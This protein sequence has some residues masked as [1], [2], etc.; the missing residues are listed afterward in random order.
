[1]QKNT[2]RIILGVVLVAI[3]VGGFIV[4]RPWFQDRTVSVTVNETIERP[5]LNIAFTFPSGEDAYSY[6]EPVFDASSTPGGPE[7][8]FIMMKSDAYTDY[9]NAAEGSD[10]PPVMSIFVFP[11]PPEPAVATASGTPELDRMG[12]LRVWADAN[13][14]LTGYQR[15]L[16]APEEVE[17]DGTRGLHYKTDGL[18]PQD[19]YIVFHR[20]RYYL[21]MG[22]YNGESDP[23]YEAFKNLVSTITFM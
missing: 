10:A 1:M 4:L 7:A 11:K 22:Q 6:L 20:S 5:A 23:Q 13:T 19:V 3:I 15:A 14:G 8:A 16:G 17:I 18:Y 9:Q 21:I 12:K 2:Q